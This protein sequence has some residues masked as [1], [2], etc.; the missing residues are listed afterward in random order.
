MG[1]TKEVL[2]PEQY[3][4]L[5]RYGIGLTDVAKTHAGRD[6]EIPEHAFDP[7]ALVAKLMD[8]KPKVVCFNGKTAAKRFFGIRKVEFGKYKSG[9]PALPSITFFVAPSTSGAACGSWDLE[10]WRDLA[11]IVS[12]HHS[13]PVGGIA[14]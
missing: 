2:K 3:R 10:I 1:L 7:E 9:H 11:R 14:G 13:G 6:P 12:E 8:I 5:L 4:Q